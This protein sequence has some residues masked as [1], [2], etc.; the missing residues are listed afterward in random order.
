MSR[1]R[2]R[3]SYDPEA[4]RTR[5]KTMYMN[6]YYN[7][8]MNMFEWE[9]LDDEQ[10][11]YLMKK[12]WC[13]G[14]IAAFKIKNID[15]LG[16]APY[17]EFEWNMYDFAEKVNLIN[18]RGV[19]FIPSSV[20]VVNKDVVLGW[21]QN[22]HKS[23]KQIAEYYIDRMVQVDM[24][25]NTNIELHKMPYL[26]GV[27]STDKAKLDDVVDRI[28]NNELVVYTDFDVLNLVQSL[29]T[30]PQYIIDKLHAYRIQMEN[31]LLSFFG[32]D[33]SG[34]AEKA[35]TMLLDEINSNNEFIN[36][37]QDQFNTCLDKFCKKVKEVLNKDIKAT[38]KFKMAEESS[39]S[40]N[41]SEGDLD[42]N[43][44]SIRN[45]EN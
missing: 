39:E 15:E 2:V 6:K 26:I 43:G 35:T 21:I 16:F 9:G 41:R 44:R 40:R 20:Q 10:E 30:A 17:A 18:E 4:L 42:E 3:Q 45:E 11:Y 32:M 33:N 19:P 12:L 8:F 37:S 25:I 1:K 31:E 14:T 13:D 38:L 27:D 34:N 23:I 5:I 29:Q 22:N 24:V 36:A 7:L 28:L